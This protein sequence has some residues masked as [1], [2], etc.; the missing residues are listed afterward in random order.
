MVNRCLSLLLAGL[1]WLSLG[2]PARA[3]GGPQLP[4]NSPAPDFTLP[5]NRGDGEISLAD[6]RGQWLVLY[7][8]PQD[9]TPG[10]TLEAQRFQQDLP[11]YQQKN[12]AIVG[13][14]VDTVDSHREFCEAEGL[15]FPL[16]ADEDGAVSK[17]YG[18]WLGGLSL[19]HTYLIDPQG[20]LRERFLAV[21]PVIHS[22]EVLAT[23]SA[24]QEQNP[25]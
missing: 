13:V 21:R 18:S 2:T 20:I 24:L 12:T 6:Y 1:L 14:S 11:Q 8:Y 7:F 19:R 22:A 25:I 5:S 16:L 23:L 3:L 15:Q 9:F 10:C 17:Q 4:L